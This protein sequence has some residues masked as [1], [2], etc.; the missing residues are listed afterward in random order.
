MHYGDLYGASSWTAVGIDSDDEEKYLNLAL[1]SWTIL[2]DIDIKSSNGKLALSKHLMNHSFMRAMIT[3]TKGNFYQIK[4]IAEEL[5]VNYP[6]FKNVEYAKTAI[7]A[8][9]SL[10]SYARIG[11]SEHLRPFLNVQVQLG[12]ENFVVCLQEFQM[13]R[14][15]ILSLTI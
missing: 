11:T 3:L 13:K 7:N 6:E 12:L 15:N 14:F 5:S 10:I 8:L 1:K 2:K 9:L 4:T